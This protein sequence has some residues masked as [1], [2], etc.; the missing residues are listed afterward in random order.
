MVG[1]LTE[2]VMVVLG[3]VSCLRD[4]LKE[5]CVLLVTFCDFSA[6]GILFSK[7]SGSIWDGN[8]VRHK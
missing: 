4:L 5:N 1:S 3:C 8:A 7:P 2:R 6:F